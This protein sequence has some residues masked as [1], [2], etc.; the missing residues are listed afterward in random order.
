[1]PRFRPG[2]DMT[3]DR[4]PGTFV[5]YEPPPRKCRRL[6][7]ATPKIEGAAHIGVPHA[8]ARYDAGM[9]SCLTASRVRNLRG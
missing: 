5:S 2:F 9:G 3:G 6:T 7:A 4:A 8:W 1:M